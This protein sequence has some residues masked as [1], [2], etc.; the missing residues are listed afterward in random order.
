MLLSSPDDTFDGAVGGVDITVDAA[1]ETPVTVTVAQTDASLVEAVED[2]VESYNALRTDLGKLTA[3]DAE[4]ADHRPAVRHER[5]ACKST[6]DCR[7]A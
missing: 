6:R 4:A 7:G 3:F 2:L 5:S 1:S